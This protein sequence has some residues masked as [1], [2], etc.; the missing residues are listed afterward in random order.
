MILIHFNTYTVYQQWN[1][2]KQN[3][4]YLF[5][6][7]PPLKY[8]LCLLRLHLFNKITLFNYSNTVIL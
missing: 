3:Y 5:N 8:I 7:T 2:V 4:L 1:I 6:Y